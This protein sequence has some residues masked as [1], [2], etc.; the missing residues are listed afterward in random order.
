MG[1]ILKLRTKFMIY[2]AEQ[3]ILVY[4]QRRGFENE[5]MKHNKLLY[6]VSG[7][8]FGHI[9]RSSVIWNEFVNN[10][11]VVCV[12]TERE[13]FFAE[14]PKNISFRKQQ[15]DVGVFQKNSLEIDLEKTKLAI[16][17][18]QT[19]TEDILK[20]EEKFLLEYKPDLIFSDSSSLIFPLA[21]KLKIPAYFIGNFTWDFIYKNYA[22]YD[23]FFEEYAKKISE[24]YSQCELGFVL[25]LD[26]PISSIQKQKKV[27]LVGRKPTLSKEEVRKQLGFTD[28][29]KYFLFSFGAYGLDANL[30]QYEKLSESYQVVVSRIE[31]FLH[32]KVFRKDDI[33]YPDIV[34]A[35]DFVVTKP[36]Y[37][38]VSE[39]YFAKTPIIYTDRGDF[40]EYPY[41][42]KQ[43]K[44]FVPAEYIQQDKLYQFDFENCIEKLETEKQNFAPISQYGEKEILN[45]FI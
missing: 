35:C 12:V 22:K 29:K 36:G 34:T 16:Q 19:R 6:Y 31:S 32:P 9:S 23:L 37:G 24:E 27:G 5:I 7:H 18:F 8:G 21:K 26:C 44:Q 38:I 43:M 11:F 41:L 20:L 10:N 17:T 39:C 25:P 3:K 14:K 45:F 15:I 28:E 4:S 13:S 33:Y 40:A 30:F 42:V 2:T 1:I